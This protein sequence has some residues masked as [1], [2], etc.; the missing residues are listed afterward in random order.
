[1]TNGNELFRFPSAVRHDPAIDAWI[2]AQEHDLGAIARNWFTQLRRCG[3]D[4][5]ELMHDGCPVA[6]VGDVAFA[7]VNVFRTH[8]NV[9]FYFGA[10][11]DDPADLLSG[12]GKRMRHVKLQPGS[13]DAG[14]LRHL[15]EDAYADVKRRL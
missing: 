15:I 11:L 13:G 8:V 12:T 9:G 14:A 5:H 1:M 10:Y 4:I 3:A 6:C 7:Y 2:S